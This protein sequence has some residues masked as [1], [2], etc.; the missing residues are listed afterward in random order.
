MDGENAQTETGPRGISLLLLSAYFSVAVLLAEPQMHYV[1]KKVVDM[2]ISLADIRT[3]L[4]GTRAIK[5]ELSSSI[6]FN[7]MYLAQRHIG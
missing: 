3:V 7:A 6:L 4:E 1:A 5:F 2:A